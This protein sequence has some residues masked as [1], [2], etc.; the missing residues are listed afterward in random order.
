MEWWDKALS[1]S[2]LSNQLSTVLKD[3]K[4]LI[5]DSNPEVICPYVLTFFGIGNSRRIGGPH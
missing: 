4:R 2:F 3:S 1:Q 5:N